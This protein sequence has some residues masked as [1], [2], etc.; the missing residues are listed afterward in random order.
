MISKETGYRPNRLVS[1]MHCVYMYSLPQRKLE[2]ECRLEEERMKIE[3]EKTTLEKDKV[4]L[5]TK[6]K[7]LGEQSECVC[8]GFKVSVCVGG[9]K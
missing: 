1:V 6:V 7:Q 3:S 9:S 2:L 4:L 5:Q 8:R